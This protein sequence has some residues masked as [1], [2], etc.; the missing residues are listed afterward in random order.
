MSDQTTPPAQ[1]P[2]PAGPGNHGAASAGVP[3][4]EPVK[5]IPVTP[6]NGVAAPI[7]AAY[8]PR[9]FARNGV[10]MMREGRD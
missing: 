3:A 8:D 9:L 2:E 4:A 6:V 7:F 1:T 5:T 10:M